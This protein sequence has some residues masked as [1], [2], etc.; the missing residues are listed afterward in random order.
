MPRLVTWAIAASATAL[1][2]GA[3]ALAWRLLDSSHY[4][5]PE[6]T[7][8]SSHE[9]FEVRAYA[10][11]IEAR[12]TMAGTRQEATRAGF[13]VLAGYIFG[14]N[15]SRTS[16]DM[17]TP[18]SAAPSSETIAMTTPV[19]A[20]PADGGWTVA[21]TMP[22]Q[23]TLDTLPVPDD[24]RIALVEAP[25]RTAAVRTFSGKASAASVLRERKALDAALETAGRSRTEE[26]TLAQFDPPWVPG[27][28][29][30]NELQAAI[31]P[32]E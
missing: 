30:R 17:T 6:Y 15:T 27:P 4:E 9:G 2:V 8:I 29:R 20:A 19:S 28:W 12:V 3:G 5:E 7:V 18:V 1:V 22:A 11:T 31:T 10:P 26:P 14:G 24:D 16:I 13:R 23:W 32:V 21:F 25:G